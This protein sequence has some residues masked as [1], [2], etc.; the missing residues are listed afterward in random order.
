MT[1]RHARWIAG[2][3]S[4]WFLFGLPAAVLA[5]AAPLPPA[6]TAPVRV[7]ADTLESYEG[8]NLLIARGNVRLEH[9]TVTL[10]ADEAEVHQNTKVFIAR[11]HVL[12]LEG[13]NRMW[14]SRLTYD[15]GSGQG[16]MEEAQGFLPPA[17][18]FVAEQVERQDERTYRLRRGRFT[19]CSVC[20]TPPYAWEFRA[21]TTTIHPGE[22]LW[23]T[24]GSFWVRGV[25]VAYL[26]VFY[27]PLGKRKTGFLFPTFGYSEDEGFIVSES[28]FWAI[29]ESRDATFSLHHLGRRGLAPELEYRYALSPTDRGRLNLF[30]LD[31]K[32]ARE[33][34]LQPGEERPDNQRF[35]V[36]FRHQESFTPALRAIA[37]I[38]ARSDDRFPREFAV[39]FE[40]RTERLSRSTASL[41]YSLSQHSVSLAGDFTD[42]LSTDVNDTL[43]RAPEL[44]VLS[45]EQPLL[46]SPLLFRQ[47]SSAVY[48][49]QRNVLQVGRLDFH[50]SVALP[51]PLRPYVT[52]TPR[53]GFRE[54]AYSRGSV[55]FESS[56]VSR[57]LVEFETELKTGLFR[58]FR[59]KGKRLRAIQHTVEPR[60]TY[61]LVPSVDQTDLPQVDGRDFVSP[62]NRLILSIEN[63]FSARLQEPSGERR[64]IQFLSLT[65]EG[66]LNV[67][68]QRRT[69]SD[70]FLGSLAPEEVR[71]AVK[72]RD[73]RPR[74]DRPGFSTAEE[75]SFSNL[76]GRLQVTPP[77]PISLRGIFAYNPEQE[78][79]ETMNLGGSARYRDLA[80]VSLDYTFNDATDEHN[81]VGRLSLKPTRS[82]T[83][84]YQVRHDLAEG[85]TLEHQG[86]VT[87]ATCCWR[88]QVLF[89]HRE[90]EIAL[91][92]ENEVFFTIELLTGTGRGPGL[93]TGFKLGQR[94]EGAAR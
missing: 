69:F 26:P 36:V 83:L 28:F 6:P 51:I 10:Y 7:Q 8:G 59:S 86:E 91:P 75:R 14:G 39:D 88:T 17:T 74:A 63:R 41:T 46:E 13:G 70:L 92:P 15:Y 80:T 67:N 65:L 72:R 64:S 30:Y 2:L 29:S 48:I 35:W 22:Y 43:L 16:V 25:P 77:W 84:G 50:P 81:L 34:P 33:E 53:V 85:R 52:I 68:P 40:R 18:S 5:Q 76:V 66:S 54:T 49:D 60:L 58:H 47:D 1:I 3:L 57:E 56:A 73:V 89:T 4:G 31:D 11:G 21:K 45:F 61:L 27:R 37:D 12:L 94:G 90:A 78:R 19:T 71:Q 82:L 79:L 20:D 42:D 55:G 9:K 24:Q 93:R 62:Q 32:R 44:S 23:G 87:Y 38:D